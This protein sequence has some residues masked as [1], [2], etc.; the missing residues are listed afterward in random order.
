MYRSR[1]SLLNF[2]YNFWMFFS[3]TLFI[4]IAIPSCNHRNGDCFCF[5][6][7]KGDGET[8][9]LLPFI[10]KKLYKNLSKKIRIYNFYHYKA[11]G[12]I[13]K[14]RKK[15]KSTNGKCTKNYFAF[16]VHKYYYC[17]VGENIIATTKIR[18]IYVAN[19]RDSDS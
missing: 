12:A 15:D 7:L 4:S 14:L 13:T 10:E 5:I 16:Q 2:W 6:N 9:S 17:T 1:S 11:E 3:I 19:Y 8:F 18:N